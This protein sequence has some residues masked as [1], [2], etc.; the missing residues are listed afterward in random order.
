[1]EKARGVR[2]WATGCL[3]ALLLVPA[4]G[5]ALVDESCPQGTERVERDTSGFREAWCARP[6]GTMHGSYWS[7]HDNGRLRSTTRYQD[8]VEEG[9]SLAWF[10]TGRPE[11]EASLRAG[12][13]HGEWKEWHP[14]GTLACSAR[15]DEGQIVGTTTWWYA[16][17]QKRL[18]GEHLDFA[19][20]GLWT[21]WW[22]NG[23]RKS[24]CSWSRG[25]LHGPCRVWNED[26]RLLF[27]GRYEAG[28]RQQA[29]SYWRSDG[30]LTGYVIDS[31]WHADEAAPVPAR[32]AR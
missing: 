7:W 19:N 22:E 12:R 10:R 16:S 31:S 2:T 17:G 14:N 29:W 11:R 24:E 25:T 1:M 30:S 9:E 15:F 20:D 3:L 27:S 23:N 13:L 4:P 6:D 21:T 32:A 18:E 28:R 26:G 5:T 8:G